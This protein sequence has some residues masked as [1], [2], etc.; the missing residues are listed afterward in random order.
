MISVELNRSGRL[1]IISATGHVSAE[2][3]EQTAGRVRDLLQQ[4]APGLHAL[5]D[6]RWLE[7][8]HPSAAPYITEIMGTLARHH[9]ASIIRIIPNP[10]RD[11]GLEML[12]QFRYSAE[13]PISTVETLVEAL[14]SLSDQNADL[15]RHQIRGKM[16]DKL[17]REITLH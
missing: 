8:I 5:T 16:G 4:A 9:V 3:V 10:G 6:F 7:S 11:I 1:L 17:L 13:L 15:G 2:E 14:D 12:A